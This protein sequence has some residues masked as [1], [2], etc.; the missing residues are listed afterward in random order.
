VRPLRALLGLLLLAG[1]ATAG[2]G[3]DY[4]TCGVRPRVTI[5]VEM[6]G[7]V[8][9][10]HATIKG[11]DA[12][13]VL[14][15]GAESVALTETALN[16]FGLALDHNR[17]LV[18]SGFGGQTRNFA[19]KLEEFRIGDLPVPDHR[20][21]VLP[22]Q[23]G[24]AALGVDGLFGVSILSVFEVD[25]DLPH[26]VVTLYG[27]HLCPD[28]VAPPWAARALVADASRSERG[29]FLVPVVLDGRA[30]TAL[31]DT[32]ASVTVVAEDAA[33]SL[34]VSRAVLEQ[35]RPAM[36]AGVGT[37]RVTAALHRF[38]T[39]EVAG[40][41]FQRPILVVGQRPGP[42]IDM[43]LGSDYLAHRHIWLSYA[44]RVVFIDRPPVP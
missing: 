17:V 22:P 27:G 1:C 42:N 38:G 7:N 30:F 18:G 14:D 19:G 4:D 21:S 12:S 44:R 34:G 37:Q 28:T 13:F 20:V 43:I 41:T 9:V 15:T 2:D 5:P 24:V 16:R 40:Q 36:L 6:R 31:L 26:H 35:D 29:R 39:I 10:M 32:G 11:Q 8:P 3:F 25:L 33:A 23:T